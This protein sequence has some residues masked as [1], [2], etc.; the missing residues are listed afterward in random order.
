MLL[1]ADQTERAQRS[2]SGPITS[3]EASDLLSSSYEC[4]FSGPANPAQSSP[5]TVVEV[6]EGKMSKRTA[7]QWRACACRCERPKANQEKPQLS[8]P[9]KT[10]H[11]C[12]RPACSLH[13]PTFPATLMLLDPSETLNR[14]EFVNKAAAHFVFWIIRVLESGSTP[15]CQYVL[16]LSLV[17]GRDI[18]S[19]R[20]SWPPGSLRAR[21]LFFHPCSL[22]EPRRH[23]CFLLA[24][25]G[26]G[27]SVSDH[28]CYTIH[29]SLH[30]TIFSKVISIHLRLK[31]LQAL[32]PIRGPKY[33][34]PP[35]L[36]E[37][38]TNSNRTA[39]QGVRRCV[40]CS[41]SPVGQIACRAVIRIGYPTPR[42]KR[43]VIRPLHATLL[44]LMGQY[45]LPKSVG[46]ISQA[47][48]RPES[49]MLAEQIPTV[50]RC[51][52]ESMRVRI[53]DRKRPQQNTSS[54]Y[55]VWEEF[56]L[57]AERIPT[58]MAATSRVLGSV[59]EDGQGAF[60][61]RGLKG[62]AS[63]S[64]H[65]IRFGF[66]PDLFRRLPW[67]TGEWHASFGVSS[68]LL[69]R[70]SSS[71]MQVNSAWADRLATFE[72]KLL[73]CCTPPAASEAEQAV[74]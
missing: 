46:M 47:R 74:L 3:C 26:H 30:E 5:R 60:R 72:A 61:G 25:A 68:H 11:T 22:P 42:L 40:Q 34:S 8:P 29:R 57:S 43:N 37:R 27:V 38:D 36:H 54:V 9:V 1:V 19:R 51:Y 65:I 15:V 24:L 10:S 69:T 31:V 59:I 17:D 41:R 13:P 45:K 53:S 2:T 32:L 39:Q 4:G 23:G 20:S 16:Q 44:R 64:T 73:L 49:A 67:E 63:F 48:V 66:P 33:A 58:S 6:M 21:A 71:H 70:F 14:Q 7:A 56:S 18:L 28:R 52:L 50:V 55:T 12:H 35:S 62:S